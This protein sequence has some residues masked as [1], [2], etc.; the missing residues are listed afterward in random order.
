MNCFLPTLILAASLGSLQAIDWPEFYIL[1]SV[2][3]LPEYMQI[4]ILLGVGFK[5]SRSY[6]KMS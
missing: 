4:Q 6:L 1:L 5:I 3:S 2:S